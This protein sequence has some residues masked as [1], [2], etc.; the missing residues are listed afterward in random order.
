MR[1]HKN[2]LRTR[3]YQE[4]FAANV[5]NKEIKNTYL[6]NTKNLRYEKISN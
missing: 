2:I 1:H 3:R 5:Y 6:N 4:D